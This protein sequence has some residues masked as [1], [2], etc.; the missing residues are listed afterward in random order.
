MINRV[1]I[2]TD[3]ASS[4]HQNNLSVT[5]LLEN[6]LFI[7]HHPFSEMGVVQPGEA[8]LHRSSFSIQKM[9]AA[10]QGSRGVTVAVNLAMASSSVAS[11]MQME[12]NMVAMAIW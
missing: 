3:G 9:L 2:R 10:N 7:L 5:P 8:R 11:P 4:K 1:T 6:L 12:L